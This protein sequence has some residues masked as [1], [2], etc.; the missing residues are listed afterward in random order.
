MKQ[1]YID[2]CHIKCCCSENT[3]KE[4]NN[5]FLHFLDK[6]RDVIVSNGRKWVEEL[7]VD[8]YFVARY[9]VKCGWMGPESFMRYWRQ[10]RGGE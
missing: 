9:I 1:R 10:A 8:R 4:K 6:N 7:R 3:L 2:Q 5:T